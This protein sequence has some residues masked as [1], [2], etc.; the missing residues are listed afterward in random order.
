METPI[1]YLRQIATFQKEV[2]YCKWYYK[3]Q[4]VADPHLVVSMNVWLLYYLSGLES[5]QILPF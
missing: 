5:K 4:I 1:S 2:A 3:Q